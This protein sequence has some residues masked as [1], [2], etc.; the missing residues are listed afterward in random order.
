MIARAASRPECRR[1]TAPTGPRPSVPSPCVPSRSS[2]SPGSRSSG[3]APVTLSVTAQGSRSPS[4]PSAPPRITPHQ[5][6]GHGCVLI[7]VGQDQDERD[8]QEADDQE[9]SRVIKDSSIN[10]HGSQLISHSQSHSQQPQ[11]PP[12]RRVPTPLDPLLALKSS[13]AV[14]STLPL[15]SGPTGSTHLHSSTSSHS[16]TTLTL[17]SCADSN[18]DSASRLDDPN[19]PLPTPQQAHTSL[20]GPVSP[21]P[22]QLAATDTANTASDNVWSALSAAQEPEPKRKQIL[23]PTVTRAVTHPK[24]QAQAQ[25]RE[26]HTLTHE[27]DH[28]THSPGWH[29]RASASTSDRAQQR[30]TPSLA[31]VTSLSPLVTSLPSSSTSTPTGYSLKH[32]HRPHDLEALDVPVSATQEYF[33]TH[34]DHSPNVHAHAQGDTTHSPSRHNLSHSTH[35][36]S[37]GSYDD[38]TTVLRTEEYARAAHASVPQLEPQPLSSSSVTSEV[39]LAHSEDPSLVLSAPDE[40]QHGPR[41]PRITPAHPERQGYHLVERSEPEPTLRPPEPESYCRPSDSTST[42]AGRSESSAPAP[43]LSTGTSPTE[44][45]KTAPVPSLQRRID[46]S[47][48]PSTSTLTTPTQTSAHLKRRPS[49]S[50]SLSILRDSL[51]PRTR[52]FSDEG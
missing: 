32:T 40:L 34:S 29:I 9:D 25:A 26:T 28:E 38:C 45:P 14:D 8:L 43:A 15:N 44:S 48:T 31:L 6:W 1:P 16:P 46:S 24:A 2:G 17:N 47:S 41:E 20:T 10:S 52:S 39:S 33:A 18:S 50:K 42:S 13:V 22:A 23:D 7:T 49:L 19:S 21:A 51:R 37:Y 5:Q 35:P 3:S 30:A 11:R 4:P 12:L 36:R 27:Y